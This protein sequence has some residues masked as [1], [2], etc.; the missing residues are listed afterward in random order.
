[1][2]IGMVVLGLPLV[3]LLGLVGIDVSSWR[4]DAI[5][6]LLL[7][8]AFTMI[9]PMAGW[10]RHRGHAWGR[11]WEMTGSMVVPSVAAIGLLWAGIA[12]DPD[13]LLHIQH[14]EAQHIGV[15]D[16][17]AAV[18][19]ALCRHHQML[20]FSQPVRAANGLQSFGG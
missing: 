16:Q 8:M 2:F 12:E 4:E 5:E 1:M 17:Q 7:G 11:V 10:M 19:V 3:A 14:I 20:D 6:L 9:V 15:V 13:A 18:D